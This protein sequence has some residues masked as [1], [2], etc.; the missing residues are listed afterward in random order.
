MMQD[1]ATLSGVFM[2]LSRFAA[3]SSRSAQL[4][5][6]LSALTPLLT[7]AFLVQ[8]AVSP[9]HAEFRQAPNGRV[10]IDIDERFSPSDRFSGFADKES[11]ASFVIIEL[12]LAAYPEIKTMP[13][14]KEALAQQGMTDPEK[15]PLKG[16][17][18]DYI[19]FTGKQAGPTGSFTKF[20]VIFPENGVTA[21]I[22]ANMPDKALEAG[23]FT[24]EQMETILATATVKDKPAAAE[25][26]F[27]FT[28]LGPFKEAFALGGVSKLYNTSGAMP[29]SGENG[30]IKEPML[31]VSPSI[32][33]RP[34]EAK[35]VAQRSFNTLSGLKDKQIDSEKAVTIGGLDGYQIIGSGADASTGDKVALN[36]VYLAET[37]GGYFAIVASTPVS[38]SSK[39]V[40]EIQKVIESFEP[41]KQ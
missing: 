36:L 39:F 32:D 2:T 9:A 16:R 14:R 13:D 19:Y 41:V 30:M 34:I 40:D 7:A 21:M 25:G 37:D 12:P 11:G 1:Q 38:D 28:Y 20:I 26:P 22:I 35:G 5:Q 29:Q 6:M 33:K 4:R 15:K 8:F 17:D 24:S 31:M 3:S 27:R 10:A 23:T 18:G